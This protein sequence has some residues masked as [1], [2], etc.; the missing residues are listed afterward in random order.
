MKRLVLTLGL[1]PE[2]QAFLHL[3]LPFLAAY[4]RRIGADCRVIT[5][6]TQGDP[7]M[8]NFEKFQ[9]QSYFRDYERI[10][11]VDAD[12]LVLPHAPDIF[13]AVGARDFAAWD[14]SSL[15]PGPG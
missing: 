6:P 2:G 10:L 13:A 7:L 12:V 15:V 8:W 11:Y 3:S 14:E 1:G 4:A 9:I 5:Q